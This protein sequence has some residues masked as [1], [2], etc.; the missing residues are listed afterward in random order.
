[1]DGSHNLSLIIVITYL[2]R[3]KNCY[4]DNKLDSLL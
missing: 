1:M 2:A 3:T 4:L